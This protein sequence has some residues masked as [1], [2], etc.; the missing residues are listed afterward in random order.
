MG[1]PDNAYRYLENEDFF[2]NEWSY[3][4]NELPWEIRAELKGFEA[5]LN[6]FTGEKYNITTEKGRSDINYAFTF[7]FNRE[8]DRCTDEQLKELFPY[9]SEIFNKWKNEKPL[10]GDLY[11]VVFS[12]V[13]FW[14]G[15]NTLPYSMI[16]H[17]IQSH[18]KLL[19]CLNQKK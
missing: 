17:T 4:F 10:I 1:I 9:K 2:R 14:G 6:A 3:S 16:I 5:V 19:S 11:E 13:F 8:K 12:M 15:I 7:G 18:Q